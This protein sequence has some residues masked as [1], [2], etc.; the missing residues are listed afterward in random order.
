MRLVVGLSIALGFAFGCGGHT[1]PGGGSDTTDSGTMQV[2]ADAPP[3]SG[4]EYSLQW[5]PVNVDPGVENTQCIWLKLGN[6]SEIKVHQV[7]NILSQAS[8]HLIVYKDDMDTTEQTTP[9]NCQPFT[10]AL[11]TTGMIAPIVITQ[12]KDDILTLPDGVAYTLAPNQMIKIE[13]HYINSTDNPLMWMAQVNFFAADPSTIQNEAAILFTGSP[14]IGTDPKTGIPAGQSF[15]LHQFFTVP[16][17]LDLSKSSIFAITGHEHQFGTGV[18]VSTR[19]GAGGADDAGLHARSVPVVRADHHRRE[20]TVLDPD[21]RRPRLHVHV[22]EHVELGGEVRRVG[23]RRD[24]LLLA[25]LLPVA[26]R[27][28]QQLRLARVHPHQPV[29]R[30]ERLR[31]LLPEQR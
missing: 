30:R 13:M 22:D 26:D 6:T 21:R 31:H 16:S 20:P 29:R 14:D 19:A 25:V 23:D 27:P 10:G 24:V 3:L 8:H 4:T 1:T 17:Y 11:N 12:K 2:N 18:T 15:T 9:I 5:G 7:H 28:R